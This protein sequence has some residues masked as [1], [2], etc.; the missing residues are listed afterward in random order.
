[1]P[2][3]GKKL[4]GIIVSGTNKEQFNIVTE[5]N[6]PL[7]A[8]VKVQ[9]NGNEW[10]CLVDN[11]TVK[12][13][14]LERALY[15]KR[16]SPVV[17]SQLKTL[18]EKPA[19]VYSLIPIQ[20]NGGE[21]YDIPVGEV[22]IELA[23]PEDLRK[24]I[25]QGKILLGYL[26]GTDLEVSTNIN[27]LF[28]PH[29]GVFGQTGSGKSNF[30]KLVLRQ[31]HKELPNA[32]IIILDRHNEYW[33]AFEDLTGLVTTPNLKI[34]ITKLDT[35]YYSTFFEQ[36][37]N[38]Y[39]HHTNLYAMLFTTLEGLQE[40]AKTDSG[41]VFFAEYT[42]F[43]YLDYVWSVVGRRP[44]KMDIPEEIKKEMQTVISRIRSIGVE[45]PEI[46]AK[47][48]LRRLY[49][50][51]RKRSSV[52]VERPV[53]NLGKYV[54]EQIVPGK[55]NILR[56]GNVRE[57]VYSAILSIFLLETL[58]LKEGLLEKD[59]EKLERLKETHIFIIMEEAHSYLN[60]NNED[61]LDT[62][63]TLAREGR[64]FDVHLLV[65][66]QNPGAIDEEL[67]SQLTSI[68]AFRLTTNKDIR[69]VGE[70]LGGL[71]GILQGL[72]KYRMVFYSVN[73]ITPI[74]LV[75]DTIEHKQVEGAKVEEEM[76]HLNF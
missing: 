71:E 36:L 76:D 12:A 54:L 30:V 34:D 22:E 3:N 31:I 19:I 21:I 11:K 51:R 14:E 69:R 45:N 50:I 68:A 73:F 47:A 25:P 74:P 15:S 4:T 65:V 57:N 17:L 75:I 60:K 27:T 66:A 63:L 48:L 24:T 41:K 70:A 39:P 52:L 61:M 56:L 23:N 7:K 58:M 20:M 67:F 55:I 43:D 6:L 64:K 59:N 62:A 16:L 49:Q 32:T 40:F 44:I 2:T 28:S 29:L 10:L 1:M 35:Q 26:A 9:K 5:V 53:E 46:T 13:D 37:F 33:S 18:L 8:Y 38:V 72:P 42:I